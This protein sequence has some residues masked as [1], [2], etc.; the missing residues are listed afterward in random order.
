MLHE[1]LNGALSKHEENLPQV[2]VFDPFV[3]APRSRI[4]LILAVAGGQRNP[5]L[6]VIGIPRWRSVF[7]GVIPV[8][9]ISV[10]PRDGLG[11]GQA[12]DVTV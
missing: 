7:F 1:G 4:S 12:V 5:L 3:A 9:R 10:L 2:R 6:E 8:A 11:L